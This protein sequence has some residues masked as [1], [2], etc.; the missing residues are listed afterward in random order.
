MC[1]YVCMS[2]PFGQSLW[3]FIDS[4]FIYKREFKKRLKK[5]P[6]YYTSS[7]IVLVNFCPLKHDIYLL[8]TCYIIVNL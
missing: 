7:L 6:N 5:M 4:Q 1:V 3:L 2:Y 8:N